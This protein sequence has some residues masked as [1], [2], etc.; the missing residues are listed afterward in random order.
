MAISA[1]P[2]RQVVGTGAI[3]LRRLRSH[4]TDRIPRQLVAWWLR[5]ARGRAL[6]AKLRA[7]LAFAPGERPLMVGRDSAD[8]YAL[9]A[10][11]RALHHRTGRDGWSRLGWDLGVADSYREEP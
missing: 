11:D 4:F 7:Q 10:T 1:R 8:G 2:P 5:L 9:V 3:D 6:P